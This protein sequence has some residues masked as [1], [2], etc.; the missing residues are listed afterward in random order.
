MKYYRIEPNFLYTEKKIGSILEYF[1]Q[2]S[3]SECFQPVHY[4]I[5]LYGVTSTLLQYYYSNYYHVFSPWHVAPGDFLNS[6][7][8]TTVLFTASTVPIV[9]T[10][11]MV[12][13][14]DIISK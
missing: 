14:L 4:H 2:I 8:K 6:S 5:F 12:I 3:F 1:L 10:N 13:Q 11:I 7:I 9:R